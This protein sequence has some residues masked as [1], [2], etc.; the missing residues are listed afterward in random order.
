MA[1]HLFVLAECHSSKSNPQNRYYDLI[2]STRVGGLGHALFLFMSSAREKVGY[3]YPDVNSV[4]AGL[5][6]DEMFKAPTANLSDGGYNMYKE[7]L[8]WIGRP[9]QNVPQQPTPPLRVSISKKLR[10]Y[11]ED[12]YNRA[13][14]EKGKYVVVHGIASDSVA[15][16]KS[17]G[18]DDCLL[19]LEHWAEIAKAIR[20]AP[21]HDTS[22]E[23]LHCDVIYSFSEC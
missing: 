20:W 22:Y 8:E 16:M 4:G 23:L 10:A 7:L 15:N 13:G 9:R 18:D 1:G 19:P 11:V 12:K 21:H 14:V 6:L 3:V 2:L 5:F 17:R